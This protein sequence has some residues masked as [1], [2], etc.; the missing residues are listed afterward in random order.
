MR[1]SGTTMRMGNT[2]VTDEERA[3]IKRLMENEQAEGAMRDC[4]GAYRQSFMPIA[5]QIRGMY[6][7]LRNVGF[8][9]N[10]AFVI[11]LSQMNK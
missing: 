4:I 7:A 2:Y 5:M 8:G 1:G 9:S 6:D 3:Y 11:M 10:E